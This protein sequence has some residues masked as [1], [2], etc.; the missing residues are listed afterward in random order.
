MIG[1]IVNCLH[2]S[3]FFFFLVFDNKDM[4][5][6]KIK[7]GQWLVVVKLIDNLCSINVN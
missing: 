7:A 2:V 5:I 3:N 1:Q 4:V 6:R